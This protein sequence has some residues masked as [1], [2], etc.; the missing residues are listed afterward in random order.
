VHVD[1]RRSIF[2]AGGYLII[3]IAEWN[4]LSSVYIQVAHLNAVFIHRSIRYKLRGPT[5]LDLA[6]EV[7]VRSGAESS[8]ILR[9]NSDE[10]YV[11]GNDP[12][13]KPS[14]PVKTFAFKGGNPPGGGSG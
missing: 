12:L 1:S 8:V 13:P 2:G 4:C 7:V 6:I 10:V 3:F 14:D 11:R 5:T 9:M